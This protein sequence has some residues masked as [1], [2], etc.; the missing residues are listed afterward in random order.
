M[1]FK[2]LVK[3]QIQRAK[4]IGSLG[5]TFTRL[6]GTER[7]E[8]VGSSSPASAQQFYNWV[9]DANEENIRDSEKILFS[10]RPKMRRHD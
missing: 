10:R 1:K 5:D 2:I 4:T 3:S 9:T 8:A 7:R 6:Q